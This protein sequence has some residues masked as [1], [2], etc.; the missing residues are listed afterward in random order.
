[1]ACVHG[2]LGY[3]CPECLRALSDSASNALR[4]SAEIVHKARG[5]QPIATK[6]PTSEQSGIIVSDGIRRW[7]DHPG[8]KEA[9]GN[10]LDDEP[11]AKWWFELPPLPK[12]DPK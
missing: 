12:A 5:W 3:R 7:F 10:W 9:L 4:S 1:M 6:P 11:E 8:M 2:N